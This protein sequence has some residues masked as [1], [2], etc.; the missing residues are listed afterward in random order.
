MSIS[1][2]PNLEEYSQRLIYVADDEFW[3]ELLADEERLIDF[4]K[5][6]DSLSVNM[7]RLVPRMISIQTIDS[8]FYGFFESLH[9]VIGH[10]GFR[11]VPLREPTFPTVH[12]A[13]ESVTKKQILFAP[14]SLDDYKYSALEILNFLC[15]NLIEN[16]ESSQ[17]VNDVK[18]RIVN[19]SLIYPSII[20]VINYHE[21]I[22]PEKLIPSLEYFSTAY[23][24]YRNKLQR[25][26]MVYSLRDFQSTVESP[27]GSILRTVEPIFCPPYSYKINGKPDRSVAEQ[28]SVFKFTSQS[29]NGDVT[30]FTISNLE[31]IYDR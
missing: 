22:E 31:A 29:S 2:E 24:A 1:E 11:L 25:D 4:L 6:I 3:P 15:S 13:F 28:P 7:A 20:E 21:S 27:D 23:N 8:V 18:Q 12:E 26:A 9:R 19:V 30:S 5:K 16:S 17:I 14:D 10:L